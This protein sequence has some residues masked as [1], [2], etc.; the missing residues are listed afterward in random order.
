M[1]ESET[2]GKR[3]AISGQPSAYRTERLLRGSPDLPQPGEDRQAC[4]IVY[5][6]S[7]KMANSVRY[8]TDFRVVPIN[9]FTNPFVPEGSRCTTIPWP[10]IELLFAPFA[11]F[12]F[13]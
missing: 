2:M 11:I 9:T 4:L 1:I 5:E 10:S 12:L 8:R 13:R 6:C 7:N 3:S